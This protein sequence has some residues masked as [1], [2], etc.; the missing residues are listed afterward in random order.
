MAEPGPY[1]SGNLKEGEGGRFFDDYCNWTR[2]PEFEQV[3]H[4]SPAAEVAADLMGSNRVQ[5]FHDHILVKGNY[6]ATLF[7]LPLGATI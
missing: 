3:I 6:S 2:I 7:L 4:T 1:A 5:V